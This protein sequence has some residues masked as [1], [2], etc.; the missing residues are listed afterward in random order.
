MQLAAAST[1]TAGKLKVLAD[2]DD[3]D[4]RA[5]QYDCRARYIMASCKD[6]VLGTRALFATYH[7][8]DNRAQQIVAD[9]IVVVST[10]RTADVEEPDR[11]GYRQPRYELLIAV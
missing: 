3:R 5:D 11:D 8:C 10:Y 6:R 4:L 1:R 2:D 7:V 9:H